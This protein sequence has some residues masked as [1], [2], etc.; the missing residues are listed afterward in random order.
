MILDQ[1]LILHSLIRVRKKLYR[2][3]ENS[4]LCL[5]YGVGNILKRPQEGEQVIFLFSSPFGH[6]V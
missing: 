3:S 6:C 2:Q 5:Y 1:W 4:R